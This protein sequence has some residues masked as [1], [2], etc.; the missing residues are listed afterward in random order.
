MAAPSLKE[1]SKNASARARLIESALRT[2]DIEASGIGELAS[3][4]R[5][6]LG[7][8]LT[9]TVDLI[10]NSQGRLIVTGMGKS[11]H[12]G[13]KIAA[14]LSAELATT[15]VTTHPEFGPLAPL[16]ASPGFFFFRESTSAASLEIRKSKLFARSNYR[17][18]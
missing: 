11:G 18:S 7:E 13:R 1:R 15:P 3:A 9:T 17:Y 2:L 10:R 6:G 16:T 12:I 5:D 4:I 14:M 8:A